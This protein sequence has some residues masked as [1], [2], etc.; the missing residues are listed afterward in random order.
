MQRGLHLQRQ[1]DGSRQHEYKTEAHPDVHL[2]T[3]H[4]V[5]YTVRGEV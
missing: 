5:G 3:L 2:L 4:K 1:E